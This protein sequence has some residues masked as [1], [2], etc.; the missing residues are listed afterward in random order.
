MKQPL[1]GM[2]EVRRRGFRLTGLTAVISPAGK[3]NI[4]MEW[5]GDGRQHSF[6]SVARKEIRLKATE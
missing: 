2:L 3:Y 1:A 6:E 5:L 4:A